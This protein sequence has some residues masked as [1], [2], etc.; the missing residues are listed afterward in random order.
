MSSSYTAWQTGVFSLGQLI[1][2]ALANV[3]PA[4]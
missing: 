2:V 3:Q 1:S 4:R